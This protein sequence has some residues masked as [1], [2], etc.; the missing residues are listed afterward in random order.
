MRTQ[1][2]RALLRNG[3][4]MPLVSATALV[5][6][7]PA[8]A[9]GSVA[10]SVTGKWRLTAALDAADIASLD[11][12]EAQQLVGHVFVISKEKVK[13]DERDCGPTG[14][15]AVAVVP[16]LHL[17][18]E[19]HAN[20]QKLRLPNPVTVVDLSCT[21]VF[22]KIRYKVVIAWHGWFFDEVRLSPLRVLTLAE[23]RVPLSPPP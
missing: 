18:K 15:E 2:C 9:A 23:V 4:L 3:W 11:E 1:A 19:F 16:E 17:R 10:S 8:Q 7:S 22:I 6:S 21:S 5:S 20:A 13:F 14:Y 12:H